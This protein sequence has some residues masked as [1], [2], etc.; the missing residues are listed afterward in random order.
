[1]KYFRSIAN[2]FPKGK[3]WNVNKGTNIGAVVE[4][5]GNE[6]GRLRVRVDDIIKEYLYVS[7]EETISEWEN[8]FAISRVAR[9]DSETDEAYLQRRRDSIRA[10]L[11]KRN[12]QSF[13]NLKNR[14]GD[15]TVDIIKAKPTFVPFR[16]GDMLRHNALRNT[17]IFRNLT[18]NDGGAVT[19]NDVNNIKKILESIIT[20]YALFRM[21]V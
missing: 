1:M 4:S 8:E 14:I 9:V 18:K 16:A 13:G 15:F 17:F 5:V 6:V 2:L 7:A 19:E 20:A 3:L 21:E 12:N 11:E 10:F